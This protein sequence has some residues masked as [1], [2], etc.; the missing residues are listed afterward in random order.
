MTASPAEALERQL[1]QLDRT[2]NP[3]GWALAAGRVA[4]A[5]AEV[6]DPNGALTL[7]E[8]AAAVLTASRAPME[9]GRLL[10]GAAVAHRA[11]GDGPRALELFKA[12]TDLL[13]G[14]AGAVEVAAAHSNIGLVAAELGRTDEALAA[15]DAALL[16]APGDDPRLLASLYV[17]R[18]QV[19]LARGDAV[20]LHSAR[21]DFAAAAACSDSTSSPVQH[22]QAHNGL[23]AVAQ[24]TGDHAN[25]A[26]HFMAAVATFTPLQFPFQHAVANHNLG[27]ALAD[28][29]GEIAS[30]RRALVAFEV[31]LTLFDPNRHRAHW[32][33]SFRRAEAVDAMLG[34]GFPGWTRD[35]HF[36]AMVA[37]LGDDE[38]LSAV[39]TRLGHIAQRPDPHRRRAFASLAAAALR[40]SDS[41]QRSALRATLSVLMEL[42]EPVLKSGLGGQTDAHNALETD[43]ERSRAD[44]AFDDAIHEMLHGP[45]RVRVRDLLEELGWQR[46]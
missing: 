17:N 6:G 43:D 3:D 26:E 14:R 32:A 24:A 30:R 45:Q 27:L 40:R 10:V 37:E 19:H 7:L 29:A 39:R 5:R 23:G 20:G 34:V 8:Q 31:A 41:T 1:A 18:G 25:A 28:P 12:G 2:A 42:P 16:L 11:L 21:I 9:H 38:R 4:M 33:E 15:F 44:S 36:T 13:V 46:P 22:G 35:D